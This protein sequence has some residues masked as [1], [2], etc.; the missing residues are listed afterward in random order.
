M[1][2]LFKKLG[3]IQLTSGKVV[4]SDPC[5]ERGTWCM[6]GLSDVL[7]GTWETAI[8]H[9]PACPADVTDIIARWEYNRVHELMA[10]HTDHQELISAGAANDYSQWE[11]ADFHVGV[12]SG[13]AGIFDDTFYRND[14]V[15]EESDKPKDEMWK[16]RSERL[17][18]AFYGGCCERTCCGDSGDRKYAGTLSRG[19]VSSSGY[20][21]GG[22]VC[23]YKRVNNQIVA[24]AIIYMVHTGCKYPKELEDELAI[25]D[26]EDAT[27]NATENET[28]V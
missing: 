15:L 10:A 7:P 19:V 3:S 21:D 12:D 26:E 22:Y 9:S 5:Y 28:K 8:V 14:G 16:N 20:G 25:F 1:D 6:G 11:V 13:Q 18:D 27:E 4:V 24:I 17:G 2:L 23:L